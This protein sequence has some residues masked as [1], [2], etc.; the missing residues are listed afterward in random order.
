M[1]SIAPSNYGKIGNNSAS[2]QGRGVTAALPQ[3]TM[4]LRQLEAELSASYVA[5]RQRGLKLDLTRGRPGP[6]QVALASALDGVLGGD[7]CT[8]SG[9]DT[10]G[11]GGLLGIPEARRLLGELLQAPPEQS[12]VGGN[13]SLELMYRCLS[14]AY[15]HGIGNQPPWR[16]QGTVRFLCLTPGY[17][18]HFRICEALGIEMTAV[19]LGA[20][21]PDM[22]VVDEAVADP[23]VKGIW[24][25]PRFSNPSGIC[26]SE[27]TVVRMARLGQR[28]APDFRLFWDLA[29]AIHAFSP[30]A[31]EPPSGLL[32]LCSQAGT[33]DSALLFGS[34]S[35]ISFASGG[36]AALASSAGN[37]E[38]FSRHLAVTTVG[39]DKV[40]Q[41]RH[42]RLFPNLDALREHMRGHAALLRPRFAAVDSVLSAELGDREQSPYGRWNAPCGGYFV[43]FN[44]LPGL[45]T[46]V[47]QLA[48][49]AGLALTPAG[50][51]WPLGLDPADSDIRIAPTVPSIAELEQAMALFANCVRLATVRAALAE[52]GG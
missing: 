8:E 12:L 18:R 36:V 35:K 31:P 46:T 26:Y 42:T 47:I 28:A 49:E 40:N 7:F 39:P 13:S 25:V 6:E 41:L 30:D 38:W 27:E 33:E 45:A 19:P 17:D 1:R 14:F 9:T 29:Y 20:A 10:R 44:T 24:C 50:A 23:A 34:T 15:L 2:A 21:G 4:A 16:E 3:D 5:W 11:Y 43:L 52:R 48:A 37:L 32:G 51:T 22:D